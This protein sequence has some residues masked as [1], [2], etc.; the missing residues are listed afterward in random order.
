M[1]YI[2]MATMDQIAVCNKQGVIRN[3]STDS[4]TRRLD[5]T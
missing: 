5:T 2:F 3:K 4:L 1:N